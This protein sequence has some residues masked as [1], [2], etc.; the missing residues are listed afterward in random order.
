[1]LVNEYLKGAQTFQICV[2]IMVCLNN[3]FYFPILVNICLLSKFNA[4]VYFGLMGINGII[5]ITCSKMLYCQHVFKK[6]YESKDRYFFLIF[7]NLMSIYPDS[8]LMTPK[9][10]PFRHKW[11]FIISTFINWILLTGIILL[12]IG[13]TDSQPF[14]QTLSIWMLDFLLISFAGNIFVIHLSH[15]DYW[16]PQD[17]EIEKEQ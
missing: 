4:I 2:S 13:S 11:C 3:L 6:M 15:F 10:R 9:G 1:M 12:G 14:L 8:F 17:P 7:E 16:L 5:F